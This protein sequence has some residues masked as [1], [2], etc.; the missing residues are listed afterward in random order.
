MSANSEKM[1]MIS[2]A[3]SASIVTIAVRANNAT[4]AITSSAIPYTANPF[5]QSRSKYSASE[6]RSIIIAPTAYPKI[7]P[8]AQK[9]WFVAI[10]RVLDALLIEGG[11][12]GRIGEVHGQH[13]VQDAV[14]LQVGLDLVLLRLG[15]RAGAGPQLDD[16]A[17]VRRA[18]H[19]IAVPPRAGE[20]GEIRVAVLRAVGIVPERDR[21]GRERPRADEFTGHAANRMSVGVPDV[22]GHAQSRALQFA[23]P[24]RQQRTGI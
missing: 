6:A 17:V 11:H 24:D 2:R 14:F 3:S 20:E 4:T 19:P 21:H 16:E 12:D 8:I 9:A 23:S 1:K 13:L 7:T 22:H 15:D 18:L 5:L 10:H